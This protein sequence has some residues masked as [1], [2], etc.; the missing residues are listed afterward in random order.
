M[1]VPNTFGT[2]TSAIPLSQ[3]D[4]NFATPI[5]IGNTAVQ[6]GNTVTTLNNMTLANVTISSGTITITNV[7]VTTANVSGTANIS[8][9]VVVGNET[10]GGNTTITGNITAANANVTSNL[11]LSGGTANGVAYLN[12]SKVLTTGSALVFDTSSALGVGTSTP[13]S[14]YSARIAS[15]AAAGTTALALD[16]PT[17]TNTGINFY[18][19]GTAKWTTQVLTTGEYRWFDFT[20]SAERMRLDSSGNLGLGVTPSAW[21]TS[22]YKVIEGGDGNNQG[23]I[24]FRTDSNGV[25]LFANA[26]FNGTNNIYKY[27]GTAGFYQLA[28]NTHQWYTAP[29][30]TAGNAITFTQAMTLDA[31]GD[32]GIGQT[33]PAFKLDVQVAVGGA[34][35]VRPSTSTGNAK[36]SALRLYGSDSVTTS[37]YAEVACFN[38]TAGSDT[39]AL[40]FSTGLGATIY[41][42]GRFSS[43]GNLLVGKTALGL[44]VGT[45]IDADTSTGSGVRVVSSASTSSADGFQMYSTGAGAYRFY[46][47]FNGTISATTTTISAI[48]DARFK[49]NVRE[50]DAGLSKIMALKPRLYDW[51]EGKGAD[52]KNARGFIAQEFEEVFPD[53]IDE[54]K[55]PAPEGEEPYKSVRQDLIPVL[56][57]AI[58][59]Q[60]ALI[61]QLTARITALE[62]A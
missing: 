58:Q 40:T 54:W 52:T 9:L 17:G 25:E 48:S 4:A 29:S 42:R 27:T 60:Q 6:L 34:I 19:N 10:V 43:D 36:Q 16:A 32:L 57:K 44:T 26:F 33:S 8:T 11:V 61:T 47:S 51:K 21:S 1:P 14:T 35:A 24:G 7:A 46:V 53:L 13:T 62:G 49:E 5:T 37:R 20:A 55:D 31:D 50:L 3:L 12:G 39:N 2:A 45:S 22:F 18:Y 28:G 30:G 59:E 15:L 41:E 56:V 38:D 23:A